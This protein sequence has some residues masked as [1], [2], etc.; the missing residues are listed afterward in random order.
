MYP[1]NFSPYPQTPIIQTQPQYPQ[2]IPQPQP[3]YVPQHQP[4]VAQPMMTQP[5]TQPMISYP[6]QVVH[7][8]MP[9]YNHPVMPTTGMKFNPGCYKCHGTGF[10]HKKG[11]EFF[12]YPG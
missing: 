2:Y 4:Y 9:V 12:V 1:Q 8:G 3:M 7:T 10:S 5:V 11:K 6:Q